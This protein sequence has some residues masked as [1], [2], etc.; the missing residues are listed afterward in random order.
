MAVP[1][2]HAST[3]AQSRA[4]ALERLKQQVD[5]IRSELTSKGAEVQRRMGSV[6]ADGE[7][8]PP[9]PRREKQVRDMS[10]RRVSDPANTQVQPLPQAHGGGGGGGAGMVLPQSSGSVGAVPSP[11]PPSRVSPARTS[12]VRVSP[13]RPARLDAAVAA[14]AVPPPPPPQPVSPRSPPAVPHGVGGDEEEQLRL[15]SKLAMQERQLE[16]FRKQV[17]L[18]QGLVERAV[19]QLEAR[20][21][22]KERGTERELRQQAAHDREL[23][24]LSAAAQA[25]RTSPAR[26][27]PAPPE[28]RF[29]PN[30]VL[31]L[32]L[33]EVLVACPAF[34][35]CTGAQRTRKGGYKGLSLGAA[36]FFL[37]V[38]RCLVHSSPPH[39]PLLRRG[40]LMDAT[41]LGVWRFGRRG[42]R[43]VPGCRLC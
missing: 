27:P 32:P 1:P 17:E 18:Q 5:D 30:P 9:Q 8:Q 37:F 3:A 29:D 19:G 40:T 13:V 2:E 43:V 6:S 12:P 39:Y 21:M 23:L 11:A 22:E 16:A 35:V 38:L 4:A 24:L 10:P 34:R 36:F 26:R 25:Q 28:V 41:Q 31:T 20:H 15:R 42:D 33:D 14:A 7:P